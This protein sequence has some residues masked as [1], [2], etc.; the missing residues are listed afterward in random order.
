MTR[1]SRRTARPT[2]TRA[3]EGHRFLE[4]LEPRI[5][6][7]VFTV[8]TDADNPDDPIAGSLRKAIL[9]ANALSGEDAIH[10]SSA[11]FSTPRTIT[12]TK[13]L[14]QLQGELAIVGPG[15]H[16]LTIRRNPNAPE[17]FGVFN[18]FATSLSLSGMTV[19]GGNVSDGGGG[20]G[21]RIGGASPSA[22]L[23]DMVFNANHAAGDGGAIH[24]D[25]DAPLTI[26]NSVF[27]NNTASRGGAIS[28]LGNGSLVMEHTTLSGNTAT[29][30]TAGGGGGLYFSGQASPVPPVDFVPSTL[31]V[32]NSTISNNTSAFQ[33]GAILVEVFAGELLVQ[34]ST[35]SGNVAAQAGGAIAVVAGA[36]SITLQ[37]STVTG[38]A[39]SG[40]AGGGGGIYR[41]SD[42]ANTLH[43]TNSVV[44]ENTGA[45]A[46][47]IRT[48]NFTTATAHHSAIGSSAGF[49][50]DPAS[51]NNR[52]F[53]ENPMLGPLRFNGGVTRTRM[54]LPGSPLINNGSNANVQDI[55]T[56]QRGPGYPRLI[57]PAVDI[58]AVESDSAIDTAP[59]EV[60][61]AAFDYL[62]PPLSLRFSF[63]EYVEPSFT[64]DKLF[65]VDLATG[66]R[67]H[68]DRIA[69]T[70]YDPQTNTGTFTFP[71]F[72]GG[73][74]P[75]GNYRA[76][77]VPNGITDPSGNAV[78]DTWT[79]DF[80]VLAGDANRDRTVNFDDLAIL[81]QHY[82]TTGKDFAKGNFS[83][84]PAGNVDFDD[85]ALLAQRYN[86]TLAPVP[87][88]TPRV[89]PHKPAPRKRFQPVF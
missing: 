61:A 85:L 52:P 81:A 57:G 13:P 74:L 29:N 10:F 47:D 69:V 58:G 37:S 26:R 44:S 21:L 68:R 2:R 79:F 55:Y 15:A 4:P 35:L 53:G 41:A 39:A 62:T 11:F 83:H 66:I 71:G 24:V 67:I 63:S 42:L 76:S 22:T 77:F 78:P 88:A 54:P 31:I 28:L 75:D 23:D 56:D 25:I 14:P 87:A 27:T 20:G 45:A 33:G 70:A 32:R 36:G 48:D 38:N 46:P 40:A 51:Y 19:T 50:L 86:I 89:I 82:N 18:S 30:P 60:T 64:Y 43:I 34:N 72:A 16:L 3:R 5:A 73:V 8:D 17:L 9:D 65:L 1:Q 80:Y 7:A 49:T 59:P 84:D 6:L 12:V